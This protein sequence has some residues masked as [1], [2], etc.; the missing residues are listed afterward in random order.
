MI[1]LAIVSTGRYLFVSVM[2]TDTHEMISDVASAITK[3]L[4]SVK[5]LEVI[6]D[7]CVCLC[8]I[9]SYVICIFWCVCLCFFFWSAEGGIS[10]TKMGPK[11]CQNRPK[12][13]KI[14]EK[15]SILTKNHIIWSKQLHS[16]VRGH[17]NRCT[18]W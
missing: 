3:D 4:R 10:G 2:M 14:H 12:M 7:T 15:W 9:S 5:E 16:L 18:F 17:P 8:I 13:V 11:W 1:K 6:V